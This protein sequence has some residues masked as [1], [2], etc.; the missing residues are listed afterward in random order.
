MNINNQQASQLLSMCIRVGEVTSIDPQKH[1]ARVSFPEDDNNTSYELAV[2]CRNSYSNQDYGMPDVGEDVLCLFLPDGIEDGFILGS[3]YAGEV[4]PP[5][6]NAD[7]RKTVFSDGASF[8]YNRATHSFDIQIG[9]SKIHVDQSS[10]TAETSDTIKAKATSVIVE[11]SSSVTV[12]STK[13]I[14]DAPTTEI[15][16]DVTIGGALSQGGG[17]G[18]GDASFAGAV[19]AQGDVKSGNIS[20]N[21]H[22]H[23]GVHGETSGPH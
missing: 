14:I 7:E 19:T 9:A 6:G 8:T 11:G 2:L 17:A 10:I 22:T 23:T 13:V 1:T 18:G 21:S 4:S 16:G 3:F 20:L 12:K 15:T 5:T